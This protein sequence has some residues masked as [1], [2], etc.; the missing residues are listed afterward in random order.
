MTR[1]RTSQHEIANLHEIIV[2]VKFR[3]VDLTAL[4]SVDKVTQ[5]CAKLSICIK[6]NA[7]KFRNDNLKCLERSGFTGWDVNCLE[8]A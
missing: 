7:L 4:Q 6:V 2:Y 5:S 3:K 1:S 8:G